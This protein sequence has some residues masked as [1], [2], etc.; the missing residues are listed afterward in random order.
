[1]QGEVGERCLF[2]ALQGPLRA[3][4]VPPSQMIWGLEAGDA[5]AVPPF[6]TIRDHLEMKVKGAQ[7]SNGWEFS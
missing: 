1:M 6:H 7:D 4:W 2:C 5:E 3:L